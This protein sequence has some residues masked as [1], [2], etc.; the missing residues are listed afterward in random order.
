MQAESRAINLTGTRGKLKPQ[1]HAV[2]PHGL[3]VDVSM[4]LLHM[5]RRSL[6]AAVCSTKLVHFGLGP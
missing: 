6:H 4:R 2:D 3:A 1:P 5:R